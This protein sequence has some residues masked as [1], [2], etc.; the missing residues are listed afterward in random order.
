MKFVKQETTIEVDNLDY[1]IGISKEKRHGILLP[2]TIRCLLVGASNCGKTNLMI[3]LLEHINGLRFENI[4]IFSKSLYQP[5]Y[6]ELEKKIKL[7]DGMNF[8]S[9]SNADDVI[10]PSLALPNSIMIFDDV[11]CEKQKSIREYFCMGRHNNIDSFYLSQTYS[12][13]PK[14]LIRDNTNC[15]IIFRQDLRNLKHIFND[16]ISPDMTFEKFIQ[17]SSEC[18]KEKYGFMF[19][20]K[21]SS[22]DSGRYRRGFN[23]F[24]TIS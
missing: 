23:E 16:H 22:L 19:I 5:K 13:V 7:I 11:V 18:W 15:L 12:S 1:D 8:F 20:D 6:M 3:T 14:Q 21:D 10:A 2:N 24:I 4:Y 17:M 9:F